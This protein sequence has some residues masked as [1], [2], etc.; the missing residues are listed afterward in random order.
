MVSM[1]GERHFPASA[2]FLFGL[3][4]GGFFDGIVLHQLLQ[5]H[6]MLSSWY[7][8]TNLENLELNT[9]WDGIF[10]S[11]TYLFVVGALFILWRTAKRT[12]LYWSTK[13]LAGT[14]LMG[15]GTF[16]IVEGLINHHLLGL[17]HVNET[18]APAQWIYWD[19]GF[20]IWGA[21]MLGGGLWL[22][23]DGL[24]SSGSRA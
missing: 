23:R 20:L 14:M 1:S 10:H 13:L 12:H 9:F 19:L 11:A 4:L 5:W 7:P 16:N 21:A 6:H 22:Y 24:K 8:I 2:G 17:H 3:G 18:V 15:F